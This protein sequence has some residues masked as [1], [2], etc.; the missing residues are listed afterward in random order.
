V[1]QIW[2]YLTASFITRDV[3]RKHVK[4]CV[5]ICGKLRYLEH[6]WPRRCG[7][8]AYTSLYSMHIFLTGYSR[9]LPIFQTH[10]SHPRN[11]REFMK[12]LCVCFV[13]LCVV[14]QPKSLLRRLTV[15]DSTSHT[16]T[17]TH[18]HTDSKT[19]P[20]EQSALAAAATYTKHNKQNRPTSMRSV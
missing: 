13:C 11:I 15:E 9:M 10:I 1:S 12:S 3:T 19:P 16:I 4:Y 17:H 20:N 2:L 14:Q 7:G 8:A 5:R 18:T 6:V